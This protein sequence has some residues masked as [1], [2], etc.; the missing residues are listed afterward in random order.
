MIVSTLSQG[1]LPYPGKT[2]NAVHLFKKVNGENPL[3]YKRVSLS[4]IVWGTPRESNY[5]EVGC[6]IS[7]IRGTERD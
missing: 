6:R 3:T 2:G 7:K 5:K 4:D 1:K